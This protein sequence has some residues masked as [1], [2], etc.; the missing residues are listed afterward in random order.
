MANDIHC[1]II[2][3]LASTKIRILVG[4]CL[5]LWKKDN[6]LLNTKNGYIIHSLPPSIIQS[7]DSRKY[8]GSRNFIF[9]FPL[10]EYLIC[11]S[12]FSNVSIYLNYRRILRRIELNTFELN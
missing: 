7:H 12:K 4:C 8:F 9:H 10:T 5:V 6:N 2:W 1:L 3:N 11:S